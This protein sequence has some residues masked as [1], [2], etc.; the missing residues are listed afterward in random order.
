MKVVLFTKQYFFTFKYPDIVTIDPKLINNTFQSI[1]NGN[2][3]LIKMPHNYEQYGKTV[4]FNN[5]TTR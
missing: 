2:D 4:E 3:D 1:K 5:S